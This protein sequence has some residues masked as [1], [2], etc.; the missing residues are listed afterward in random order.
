MF[1]IIKN[2]FKILFR[3]PSS[4]LLLI[5]IPSLITLAFSYMLGSEMKSSVGLINKDNGIVSDSIIDKLERTDTFSLKKMN[6]DELDCAIVGKEI[7]LA[8]IFEKD[9]SS[10]IIN[11][12][13]DTV[14][15]KSIGDSEVDATVSSLVSSEISIL[16][17][18][19]SIAKGNQDKFENLLKDFNNSKL[20][21]NLNKIKE[22][23]ISVYNSVGMQ[24]MLIMTS[25]FFVTRFIIDDEKS[26]TKDRVLLGNIS[27]A[28]YYF[29]TLITFYICLSI[30]SIFYF[31]I[32][33]ILGF[34]FATDTPIY[35]LIVLFAINF[36]AIGFNLFLITLSKTPQVAANISTIFIVAG[37]M[38]SGL[39]WPFS[40]MPES[41][42]KIGNLIPLRWA[43]IA[44]EK[45]Q[46]GLSLSDISI[47][48]FGI[49]CAGLACLLLTVVISGKKK[50]KSINY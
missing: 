32:C 22:Q 38:L 1:K 45:I 41:I 36:F 35:F 48:L 47:Y 34:D 21:Y 49:I 46:Q 4:I 40:V 30:S 24:I 43:G 9:F 37:C 29:G 23:K 44:F 16:K 3:K 12:D 50:Y 19:G 13:L 7:E 39:F 15:I 10:N 20:D 18:L 2:T 11:G 27:K 8:I 6:E 31:L 14:K 28:S 33:N 17:S 26:G 42:Q 25:S 5:V